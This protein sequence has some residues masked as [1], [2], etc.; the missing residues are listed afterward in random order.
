MDRSLKQ[1]LVGTAVLVGL[2]V[3]FVP[4][5]LDQPAIEKPKIEATNIPP[6]PEGEFSSKIVP[7]EPVQPVT[8]VTPPTVSDVTLPASES[9][10]ATTPAAKPE[11]GGAVVPEVPATSL[12]NA[13]QVA[14]TDAEQRVGVNAWVIQLG[15]FASEQNARDLEK[16]LQKEGYAAFVEKVSTGDV[17]KYRV[18]VGPELVRAKAQQER[19]RLEKELNLKGIVVRYP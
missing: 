17:E 18:R 14:K 1:R 7:L 11:D 3:I 8:P 16:R 13:E 12:G 10:P 5:L 9:A 2:A 15:S 19:D 6:R 4:I